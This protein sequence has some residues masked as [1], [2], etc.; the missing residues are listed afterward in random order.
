[1]F[2]CN[3]I[4]AILQ[5]NIHSP[6]DKKKIHTPTPRTIHTYKGFDEKEKKKSRKVTI[7]NKI[8]FI[9]NL[10]LFIPKIN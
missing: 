6:S 8:L 7:R 9:N 5:I 3:E 4:F 1:M 10:L 2:R